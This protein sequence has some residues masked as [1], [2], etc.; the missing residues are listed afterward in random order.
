[1]KSQIKSG[2][3]LTFISLFI[4][5]AISLFYTPFMLKSLGQVEYGLYGLANSIVGYLTVL[6]FGFGNAAIRYTAKYKAEN[7]EDKLKYMYGMFIALYT[8]IGILTFTIG[9]YF[10]QNAQLFFKNGLSV[11][12]LSIVRTLLILASLNLAIS[13]PFGIFTSIITAYENF[14]FLRVSSIVRHIIN[15]L[16]YIPVLLF[17]HKSIGL[18]IATTILNFLFLLI[19]LIYCFCKLKIKV[20]FGKFDFS[21][22]KEIFSYS[23]W[24]FVGSIVNQLWWNS[25][26]F[27]LGVFSSAVSIAIFNLAMQF[28]SYFESFATSISGVF[29][30]RLTSMESNQSSDE[31]FTN[32]FIK[33]GRLQFILISLITTGFILFGK[34]FIEIWAGSNYEL[35]YYVTLIIFIPL[36][37]VDTQTLGIAILQAKNKHKFRSIVYLCVAIA[38]IVICIP[39]IK[40]FDVIGCASATALVLTVGNLFIMNWYYYKK[41]HLN[42][43]LFWKEL[44][45]ML[46]SVILSCGIMFVLL[47]FFI[48]VLNSYRLLLPFILI[49][50]IFFLV[51]MYL[52]S[53]NEYEKN[54]VKVVIRKIRRI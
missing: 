53:F 23:V 43:F 8:F 50:I 38:C 30:P 39:F 26:Q 31:E 44:L 15:P 32:C 7:K 36:A 13:F 12:E 10:S 42:V 54:L 49:Y 52:F 48:P 21:L 3:V 45:K 1:M 20:S 5:N 40:K 19:N 47:K 46:P 35:A 24:I 16:V 51:I 28:K 9:Y 25:G 29:L 22:L 11:D 41:I 2:A 17:G 37:L 27:M 14:I 18:I 34:Q 33:V 6:D 4:G